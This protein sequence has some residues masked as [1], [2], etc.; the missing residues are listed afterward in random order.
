MCCVYRRHMVA[1]YARRALRKSGHGDEYI[2]NT[3]IQIREIQPQYLL[4]LLNFSTL[5]FEVLYEILI[6][7]KITI[8]SPQLKFER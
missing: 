6:A 3:H 7:E 5:I 4:K 1:R 8:P 2:S